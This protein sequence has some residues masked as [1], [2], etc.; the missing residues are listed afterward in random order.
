MAEEDEK[1]ILELPHLIDAHIAHLKCE[2]EAKIRL[3]AF[4]AHLM[5][6]EPIRT[7]TAFEKYAALAKGMYPR[8][9]DPFLLE[10]AKPHVTQ[11]R[12]PIHTHRFTLLDMDVFWRFKLNAFF[13]LLMENTARPLTITVACATKERAGELRSLMRNQHSFQ[14]RCANQV[15][16]TQ[17]I[18]PDSMLYGL[19]RTKSLL[20]VAFVHDVRAMERIVPSDIFVLDCCNEMKDWNSSFFVPIIGRLK[21]RQIIFSTTHN[22]KPIPAQIFCDMVKRTRTGKRARWKNQKKKRRGNTSITRLSRNPLYEPRI[23]RIVE[24]FL[25]TEK[26]RHVCVTKT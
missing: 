25:R 1:L 11:W 13:L 18:D 26:L 21:D 7:V 16:F 6:Y 24:S 9:D 12:V 17:G 14:S 5:E 23:W 19:R 8:V 15:Y 4:K 10:I 22:W 3:R 20:R 2:K